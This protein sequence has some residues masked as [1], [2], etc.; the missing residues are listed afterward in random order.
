MSDNE[1]NEKDIT[2]GPAEGE[3]GAG[4]AAAMPEEDTTDG[5]DPVKKLLRA[6]TGLPEQQ[7]LQAAEFAMQKAFAAQ[8]LQDYQRRRSQ[9]DS[10]SRWLDTVMV[11]LIMLNL[12]LVVYEA[13]QRAKGQ[14]HS[15]IDAANWVFLVMFVTELLCGIGSAGWEYFRHT[16]NWINIVITGTDVF[17]NILDL[18]D[19]GD[20]P[21]V[22]ILRVMRAA[23]LVRV[24]N[25]SPVLRELWLMLHGMGSAVKAMIWA[26]V[27]I[28]IILLIWSVISVEVLRPLAENMEGCIACETAFESVISAAFMWFSLI[29]AGEGWVDFAVPLMKMEPFCIPVFVVAY[30]SINLGLVN[31]IL[32]VIVDRAAEARLEDAK[33][34]LATKK[35]TREQGKKSLLR[36]CK[37][38][39]AD[40]S[41]ELELKEIQDGYKTNAEF[42]DT[43]ML[44]DIRYSDLATVFRMLDKDKSGACTYTEFVEH[45]YRMQSSEAHTMMSFIKHFIKEMQQIVDETGELMSGDDFKC[46]REHYMRFASPSRKGKRELPRGPH[47]GSP[48]E[49]PDPDEEDEILSI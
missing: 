1:V 24:I 29:F 17:C 30:V 46:M 13:D 12:C 19:W 35:A 7:A 22:A 45:L 36:I 3:A 49:P 28:V 34:T 38:M 31:L 11:A 14:S 16:M 9:A 5:P 48:E 21:A 23:R 42:N 33:S 27:L 26:C 32:S 8:R 18:L 15:W 2:D 43:L 4:P 6:A 10:R 25:T 40:G 39:D 47:P 37:S 41:G 20:P 44:M